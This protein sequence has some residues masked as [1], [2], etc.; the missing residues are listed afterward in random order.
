LYRLTHASGPIGVTHGSASTAAD[1]RQ[2]V[3][4]LRKR[5]LLFIDK[6]SGRCVL[7]L[8]CGDFLLNLLIQF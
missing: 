4:H 8:K 1:D 7:L 6:N 3:H 2:E 5:A